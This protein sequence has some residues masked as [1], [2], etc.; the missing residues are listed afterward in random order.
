MSLRFQRRVSLGGLHLNFSGSGLGLSVGTRGA[1]FGVS[2]GGHAYSSVGL[3]GT[4]LSW[5]AY[6][7][8][9]HRSQG[10]HAEWLSHLVGWLI[11]LC[12]LR[13]LVWS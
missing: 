1:R 6:S 5:R 12:L 10:P 3:P 13:W 11:V 7:H 4:G 8:D 9:G 2:S